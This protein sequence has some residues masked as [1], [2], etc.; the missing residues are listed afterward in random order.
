MKNGVIPAEQV[1]EL[2]KIYEP[3]ECIEL[4]DIRLW[5]IK[6]LKKGQ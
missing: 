1:V 4:N 6:D 3:D 5:S 2:L